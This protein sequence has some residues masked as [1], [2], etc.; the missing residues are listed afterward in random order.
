MSF[1]VYNDKDNKSFESRLPIKRIMLY[2]TPF[3]LVGLAFIVAPDLVD[4]LEYAEVMDGWVVTVEPASADGNMSQAAIL[5]KLEN[6]KY[7]LARSV[8]KQRGE[9]VI[10]SVYQRK[11]TGRESYRLNP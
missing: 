6:G 4:P 10:V 11:L 1:P 7:F 8:V 9:K 2:L 5:I 3:I